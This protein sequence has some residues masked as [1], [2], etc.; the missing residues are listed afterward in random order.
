[1][2]A[3]ITKHFHGNAQQLGGAPEWFSQLKAKIE[4]NTV[5]SQV[6]VHCIS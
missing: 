5:I 6:G 1:M 3:E 2:N 4:K